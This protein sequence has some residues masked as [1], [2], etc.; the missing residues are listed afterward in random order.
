MNTKLKKNL[1]KS[2]FYL[3]LL[4]SISGYYSCRTEKVS[5]LSNGLAEYVVSSYLH[6]NDFTG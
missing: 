6:P 1:R 4:I 2:I 3:I 5:D